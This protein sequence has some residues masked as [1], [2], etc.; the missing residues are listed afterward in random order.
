MYIHMKQNDLNSKKKK[1][2]E[3]LS[4]YAFFL[5]GSIVYWIRKW[6]QLN[7]K[8]AKQIRSKKCISLIKTCIFLFTKKKKTCLFLSRVLIL[9]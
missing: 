1:C 3:I 6:K 5:I 2:Q 7:Y 9:N 4:C 8:L